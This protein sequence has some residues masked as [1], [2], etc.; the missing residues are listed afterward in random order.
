[1]FSRRNILIGLVVLGLVAG[2]VY[3][4][5]QEQQAAEAARQAA[6]RQ[7]VAE[8]G[9]IFATVSATGNLAPQAQVNL[10]FAST[11]PA[12]ITHVNV[13][14][15]QTVNTGDLLATLDTAE[16]E[17]AV[18]QAQHS[19]ESAQLNLDQLTAP[20]RPEDLAVAEANVKVAQARV[21]QASQGA[22]ETDEQIAFLNLR[23]AWHE[24]EPVAFLIF[25]RDGNA[26]GTLRDF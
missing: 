19:L 18:A 25:H 8:Q 16:L 22:S 20:A 4:W 21:Y 26:S 9:D 10:F 12:F 6:I 5:R 17:L 11:T 13:V 3:Y 2:G 15:G 23:L 7:T 24:D 1:M 14:L